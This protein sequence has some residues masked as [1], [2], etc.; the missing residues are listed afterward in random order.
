MTPDYEI[1][2][3]DGLRADPTGASPKLAG[4]ALWPYGRMLLPS[5][6]RRKAVSLIGNILWVILAGWWIAL[7]HLVIG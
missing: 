2:A 4:Y 1:R 3:L 7:S 5:Q 6:T